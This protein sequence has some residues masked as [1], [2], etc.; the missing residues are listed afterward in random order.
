MAS[1]IRSA[2][3]IFC[4]STNA[5]IKIVSHNVLINLGIRQDGTTGTI[6]S[7][8]L[9]REKMTAGA[10]YRST[11]AG[12]LTKRLGVRI[13]PEQVGFR[14]DGVPKELCESFSKRRTAVTK[15][16][17]EMNR[18]DAVAA[19]TAA[20]ST[21]PKKTELPRKELF[22]MWRDHA[23][24]FGWEYSASV[25]KDTTPGHDKNAE[26]QFR[27]TVEK[28]VDNVFTDKRTTNRVT[29]IVAETAMQFPVSPEVQQE[30]I[31]NLAIA[32]RWISIQWKPIFKSAPWW[33]PAKNAKAPVVTI[34]KPRPFQRWKY[35]IKNKQ[36]PTLD[37]RVQQR[38]LF[39]RA[40]DWNPMGKATIP[41]LRLVAK[42]P[43]IRDLFQ[44]IRETKKHYHEK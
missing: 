4:S 38:K 15:K 8:E 40:P 35:I 44:R 29:R 5:V 11:L 17:Q 23:K 16:L 13:I 43:K 28:A 33:S 25:R 10:L 2:V 32:N 6:V 12:E 21:R 36:V 39:P 20:L 31:S 19:K 7:R 42:K 34:G 3:I 37:L 1:S 24:A 27:R 18:S 14:I 9:F 22:G 30:A 41:A 26:N